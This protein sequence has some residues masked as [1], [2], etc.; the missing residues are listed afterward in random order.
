MLAACVM[1]TGCGS[2]PNYRY[3]TLDAAIVASKPKLAESFSITVGPISLADHLGRREIVSRGSDGEVLVSKNERWAG[4]LGRNIA[5][6][7]ATSLSNST[8]STDVISYYANFHAKTDYSIDLHISEF[9]LVSAEVVRLRANWRVTVNLD[10][11]SQLHARAFEV[12]VGSMSIE[13]RIA[14]KNQAL[15]LLS[16]AVHAS[17]IQ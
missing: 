15:S 9:E 11:T 2:S 7:L 3:F 6:T 8:G 4:G 1:T 13:D 16:E 5:D 10:S 14:A 17:I 12:P